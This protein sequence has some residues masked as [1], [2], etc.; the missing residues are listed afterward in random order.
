VLS[1]LGRGKPI[2]LT[3]AR[4]PRLERDSGRHLD[5]GGGLDDAPL[6]S[7][8]ASSGVL[9]Q[10][11]VRPGWLRTSRAEFGADLVWIGVAGADAGKVAELHEDVKG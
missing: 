4:L 8:A 5:G 10:V 7:L 11:P 6:E 3:G 2:R 1:R 9:T